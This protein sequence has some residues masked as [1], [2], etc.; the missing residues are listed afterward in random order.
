MKKTKSFS[1]YLLVLMLLL[2]STGFKVNA[3]TDNI[4]G[5]SYGEVLKDQKVA[6][7]LIKGYNSKTEIKL[8][9]KGMVTNE[10]T[11]DAY[12]RIVKLSYTHHESSEVSLEGLDRFKNIKS[13]N[14]SGYMHL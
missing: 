11:Q 14:Y 6:A 5:K 3:E 9:E 13:M 12:D 2:I 10:I 1:I 8:D 4:I 7:A